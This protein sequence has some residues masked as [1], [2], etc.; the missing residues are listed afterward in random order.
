[1][2]HISQWIVDAWAKVS[3]LSVIRA[4][5]KARIIAEQLVTA[6]RLKEGSGHS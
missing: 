5:M 4:F 1:M 6:T 3:L 2:L